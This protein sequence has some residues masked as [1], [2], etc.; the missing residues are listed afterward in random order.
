MVSEAERSAPTT[1]P[2]WTALVNHAVSAGVRFH[3][4]AN[5]GPTALPLNHNVIA[6]S[7]AIPTRTSAR[8]L[9]PT[10]IDIS[11]DTTDD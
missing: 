3:I 6:N 1:N 2:S 8:H 10:T 7:S 9:V 4:S 11:R 5:S